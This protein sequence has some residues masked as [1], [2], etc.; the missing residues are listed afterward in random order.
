MSD[1][2]LML[3]DCL[4]RMGE[5]A[6]GSVDLIAA[7]LPYGTTACKWDVVIPFEPLWAHYRRVLKPRGAVVLTASQPFTSMLVMSNR[8]WFR[9]DDVWDKVGT[10]GFLDA[11]RRPLRRHEAVLVFSP[12]GKFTYNPLMRKG[13]FR[14]KGDSTGSDCYGAHAPVATFNDQYFPTSIVEFSNSDQ[15]NKVHPTQKPVALFEYLLKTYSNPGD[16]V[17]DNTMGSATTLVAAINTDRR[18]IG[19][20]KDEAIYATA[21]RRIAAHQ[22]SMPLL[23]GGAA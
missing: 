15:V 20:E 21:E 19:I 3:G 13:V 2:T 7:D 12:I 14:K 11:R 16:L 9:F 1:I 4:E 22:A 8:E 5:I 6:D 17:L 23:A 10:T 18:A